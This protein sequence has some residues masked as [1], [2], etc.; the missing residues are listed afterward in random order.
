M[1]KGRIEDWIGKAVV[2]GSVHSV[3]GTIKYG[4]KLPI[5]PGTAPLHECDLGSR[6]KIEGVRPHYYFV[7]PDQSIKVRLITHR[8][9][10]AE[11][12]GLGYDSQLV[13]YRIRKK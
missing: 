7:S 12:M 1:A 4:V 10:P 3:E 13:L 5:R 2:L 6:E 11:I 9:S 8:V